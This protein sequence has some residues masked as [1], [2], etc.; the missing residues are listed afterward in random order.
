MPTAKEYVNSIAMK[1]VR[2]EP[3]P[4]AMGFGNQPLPEGLLLPE[5]QLSKKTSF[6]NGDFDEHPTHQVEITKPFYIGMFEVTN[7]QYE[8]FDPHHRKLRG[9][10]GFSKNDDE[11]VVFVNWYN[12]AAFCKWLSEKE[13][14]PYRLPTEA[15][16]EYACRAGTETAF[17]TGD[18]LPEVFHKNVRR[19][20]YPDPRTT[21]EIVDPKW[22]D[23]KEKVLPALTVGRTPPNQWGLS[24][25]HGNVEE[26]CYDWYGPYEPGTHVDPVGRANDDFKV[27]RGGSHST[28]LYYLRSANRMGTLPEDKNWYIGFRV[29]LGETP[30]TKSLPRTPPQTYQRNVKQTVPPNLPTEPRRKTPYFKGPRTYVNIPPNSEGPLFSNHNHDPAIV[31]CPNGDLLAIWYTCVEE[32]GRELAVAASRLRY[33]AQQWEPA[34]PFWD[35]PDRNDHCPGLWFDGQ[36]TIYHFNGLSA[37]ATW[38]NLAIILRTSKDNGVTWSRARLI[39]PEH[40]FR[41]MVG[42]PAFRTDDGAIVFGADAVYGST[43]WLSRDNGLTWTDPSGTLNGIHAGIVQLKDGRLMALGRGMNIDGIMP[44][45]ISSDMGK[46]WQA[47]P[48]SFPPLSGGQRLALTRLIEGHLFFASFADK[49]IMTDAAGKKRTVS[50]LFGALS[51]DDGQTWPVRRLITDGGPGRKLN[52]GAWTGEFVMSHSNAEPKGYLSVCQTPDGLI[53]LISSA[54]HYQFNVPWLT[55][56]MPPLDR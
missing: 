16:W 54:L 4:F 43:I 13:A 7:F 14:L 35:A 23:R 11:A 15:E 48:S 51:F 24:D 28:E 10:L 29:V 1:L 38:G 44:K 56:P 33:G 30:K 40:G 21:E 17:N 52:G 25:M 19:S 37:A 6:P 50:G 26:W 8:L 9:K 2:I 34:A 27:T 32:D 36:D 3:G 18:T 12:A 42:E 41:Q 49:M 46:T 22:V 45:S 39:V 20:W 53:N 55:T 47:S 5:G 31:E